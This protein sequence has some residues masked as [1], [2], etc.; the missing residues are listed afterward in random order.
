MLT[1]QYALYG[2][3]TAKGAVPAAKV[4]G[5]LSGAAVALTVTLLAVLVYTNTITIE[6]LFSLT[7]LLGVF[8]AMA[9]PSRLALIPTLVD[10][11]AL[12]SALA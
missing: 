2:L 1:E 8:N 12:P 3:A 7:L 11:A 9:Q 10:R 4:A 6:L 5:V